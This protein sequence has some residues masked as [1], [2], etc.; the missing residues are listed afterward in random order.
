[1][2]LQ[3]GLM[4]LLAIAALVLAVMSVMNKAPLWAAVIIVTVI[5]LLR[6]IPAH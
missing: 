3:V 5:E 2:N 6:A 1:M 4:A